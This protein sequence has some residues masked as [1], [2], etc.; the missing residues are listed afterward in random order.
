MYLNCI[1]LKNLPR[2]LVPLLNAS[3]ATKQFMFNRKYPLILFGHFLWDFL[4]VH[5][6]ESMSQAHTSSG[7]S[8]PGDAPS[9]INHRGPKGSFNIQTSGEN[10]H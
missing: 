3:V 1:F 7:L 4:F 2:D 5:L 10:P 9:K 6:T 8:L